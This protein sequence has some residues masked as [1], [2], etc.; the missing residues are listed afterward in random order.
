V[1]DAARENA[2]PILLQFQD[3]RITAVP[4]GS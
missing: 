1:A 2:Y 3:R 4:E